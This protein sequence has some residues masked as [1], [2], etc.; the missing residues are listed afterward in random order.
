[1]KGNGNTVHEKLF[2]EE[3]YPYAYR[4]KFDAQVLDVTGDVFEDHR[5]STLS[6]LKDRSSTEI[7]IAGINRAGD[8]KNEIT[9]RLMLR[10][11]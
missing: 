3:S 4:S 5:K 2:A 8:L 11:N 9:W 6:L 10:N 7:N 1:M